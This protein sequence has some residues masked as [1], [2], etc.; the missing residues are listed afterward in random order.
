MIDPGKAREL[1][2]L[3]QLNQTNQDGLLT[4][5]EVEEIFSVFDIDGE[6]SMER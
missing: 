2:H 4:I 6:F 1:F 5:V 3:A